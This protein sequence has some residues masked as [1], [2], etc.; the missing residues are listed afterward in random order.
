MAK[1]RFR[2]KQSDN[3]GITLLKS[4]KGRKLHKK[5]K[6]LAIALVSSILINMYLFIK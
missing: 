4:D 6:I 5:I 1:I 2:E 3:K